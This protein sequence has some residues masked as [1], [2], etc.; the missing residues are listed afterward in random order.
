MPAGA[1]VDYK[2]EIDG[3]VDRVSSIVCGAYYVYPLSEMLQ[4]SRYALR[5]KVVVR[6][7]GTLRLKCHSL[8]GTVPVL[9]RV[10]A[11][12]WAVDPSL[13]LEFTDQSK[14]VRIVVGPPNASG[15][16]K[17]SDRGAATDPSGRRQ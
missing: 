6:K 4:S 2:I 10:Y 1:V 12:S 14:G 13:L 9:I 17:I 7:D 8:P 11:L 15:K 16:N 3:P 5:G